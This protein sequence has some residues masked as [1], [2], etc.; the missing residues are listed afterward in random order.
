M[1]FNTFT[2]GDLTIAGEGVLH[3]AALIGDA[4]ASVDIGGKLALASS[5]RLVPGPYAGM[6]VVTVQY[7]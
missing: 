6:L 5:E 3:H 1:T 2:K 4:A 7:N